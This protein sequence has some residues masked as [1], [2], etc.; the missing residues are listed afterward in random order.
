VNTNVALGQF[1]E[2]AGT[3]NVVIEQQSNATPIIGSPWDVTFALRVD[4][5]LTGGRCTS[6]WFGPTLCRLYGPGGG[7]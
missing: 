7:E 5:R 2:Q 3:P 4:G 6:Q 1:R